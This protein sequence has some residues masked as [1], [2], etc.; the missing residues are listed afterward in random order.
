MSL[1]SSAARSKSICASPVQWGWLGAIH[2]ARVTALPQ[3]RQELCQEEHRPAHPSSSATLTWDKRFLAD[4]ERGPAMGIL[5]TIIIGFIAGVIAKFLMPGPH[6]GGGTVC[7]CGCGPGQER[8][9][10]HFGGP[11]SPGKDAKARV[12]ERSDR[13]RLSD[14]MVRSADTLCRIAR[15]R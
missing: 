8:A 15:N 3:S 6:W 13:T 7:Q 1:R 4:Q 14:V 2:A 9:V 5:W 11:L 10:L 12:G